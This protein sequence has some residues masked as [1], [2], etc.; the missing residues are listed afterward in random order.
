MVR[1]RHTRGMK[2]PS[3]EAFDRP[4]VRFG[5]S[6]ACDVVFYGAPPD[7]IA[8]HA[9]LKHEAGS[10][11]LVD[12]GS[13]SGTSVGGERVAIH[14]IRPGD[15]VRLGAPGGPEFVVEVGA[16]AVE[17]PNLVDLATAQ[18]MVREAIARASSHDD[19][20]ASIVAARIEAV[21]KRAARKNF[22]LGLGVIGA[23]VGAG[24][25]GMMIW[26]AHQKASELVS[27]AGLDQRTAR[28]EE[29]VQPAE[30]PTRVMTGREIYEA[31]KTALYVLGYTSGR[32]V[33]AFCTAFAIGPNLLATNAH[34]VISARKKKDVPLFAT[35]NDTNGKVKFRIKSTSYHPSYKVGSKSADSPD[36]GLVRVEGT[37]PKVVTLATDAELRALGAG[38]DAF[39]LGFPGRVMDPLS[40][41]ATFLSGHVN[42]VTGFDGGATSPERSVLV[43]HDAVTRGGNSGSPVFNQ[44]GH[45]IALHAAHIDEEEEQQVDGRKTTVLDA[46]PYR[47][48]MRADLLRGVPKP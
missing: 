32:M 6:A 9:E 27:E 14:E 37:L 7:V 10:W 48:A 42:R 31:N 23:V 29:P 12:L 21:R 17:D 2:A 40:P 5:A 38:D 4:V 22:V 18:A 3:V 35:Q 39:V 13:R 28:A 25:V 46:S 8:V 16:E 47:I 24:F 41:S 26:R 30:L 1:I 20:T 36:V 11:T 44:Y 15:V 43:Q 33:G 19:K 34:C 45:V